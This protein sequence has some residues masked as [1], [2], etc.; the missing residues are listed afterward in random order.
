VDRSDYRIA[1][2]VAAATSEA[3]PESFADSCVP[4]TKRI[5]RGVSAADEPDGAFAPKTRPQHSFGTFVSDVLAESLLALPENAPPASVVAEA[6][7]RFRAYGID[8]D[9]PYLRRG[10]AVDDL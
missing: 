7:R 9:R 6:E 1:R 10:H 8:P 5:T 2:R 3:L 4:F